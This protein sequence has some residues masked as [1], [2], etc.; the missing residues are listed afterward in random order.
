MVKLE[1][2]AQVK[3]S[4]KSVKMVDLFKR[5]VSIIK[6]KGFIPG[7]DKAKKEVT[8]ISQDRKSVV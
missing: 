2:T 4:V 6:D 1:T 7:F 5:V 8:L 3:K